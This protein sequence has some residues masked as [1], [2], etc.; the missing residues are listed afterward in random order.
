[1]SL[2]YE[3]PFFNDRSQSN[4]VDMW[5]NKIPWSFQQDVWW[6][7][8]QVDDT[9]SSR[10]GPPSVKNGSE[11][12]EFSRSPFPMNTLKVALYTFAFTKVTWTIPFVH[13]KF[14]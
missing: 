6:Q 1:M 7:F 4:S 2:C 11:S 9:M 14:T 12:L 10:V 3:T 8:A 13:R 5:R